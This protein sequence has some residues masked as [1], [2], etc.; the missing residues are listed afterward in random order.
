GCVVDLASPSIAASLA[1]PTRRV[2]SRGDPRLSQTSHWGLKCAVH[3]VPIHDANPSLS[4]RLSHQAMV[5]RSPNHWCAISCASTSQM[6]CFVS[7]EE[8]F[9][10]NK[11]ADS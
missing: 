9:G 2:G 5:T 4:Q 11:S 8:F 3:L 1:I 10:S 7:V 6:F